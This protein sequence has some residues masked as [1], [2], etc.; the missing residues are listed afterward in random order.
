M[1]SF[2]AVAAAAAVLAAVTTGYLLDPGSPRAQAER[3]ETWITIDA[4]EFLSVSDK[5]RS[6]TGKGFAPSALINGL[7]VIRV[8]EEDL[9]V[10][11]GVMHGHHHKCAGFA[12][13]TS[14]NEA[15][16]AALLTDPAREVEN[17][18]NYTIDNQ[19][20]VTQM[21]PLAA[22]QNIRRTIQDLSS[23]DTRRHDQPSG[24]NSANYINFKWSS[25]TAGRDDI[26]VDFVTHPANVTPQPSVV[27]TITGTTFPDEIV[28]LGGHQDSINSSGATLLAPGA[29][30]NAS[31]IASLT[32]ALRV[33]VE[34][35]FRPARTVQFMAYA[36]EEVGLR[37]SR[38][39]AAN[40]Q[41]QQRN[42]TGVLQL[43]MTNFTSSTTVDIV[44]ITDFTNAAQNQFVTDLVAEYQPQLVVANGTCGYA[45]SDHASWTE[46]GFVSSFP[47]EGALG[48]VRTNN[49]EIHRATDTISVSNN[50]ANHAL[51]FSRLAI[52]F[53]GE[54]AKGSVAAT[55]SAAPFDFDGDGKTDVSIFRPDPSSVA[56]EG[57]SSQ[58]WMLNS[59]DLSTLGLTFGTA[60]DVPVPADYTGDGRTDVTF[61]RPSTGEW[62][63]LRSE[64]YT[65]FAFPFG[66][67]G[68]IPA[69]GDFDGDGR[70][71]AA[72]YRPS[73]GTWF[74]LRSSD[75][76][77]SAVPFGTAEDKPT[78]ADFD[79]DGADDI[80]VYRPSVNQWWQLRSTAGVIGI[81]FGSAGDVSA[82]GDYTGDARADVAFYRPS[83]SEWFVLR[84]EDFSFFAFQWGAPGD[85][86]VPGD[87]DGD[88]ITDAAVFRG[89]DTTWYINRSSSGFQAVPFGAAS[90]TPLPGVFSVQ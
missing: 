41:T 31:G 10:I 67:P 68:D 89:S 38:D 23:Y 66:A 84:S 14:E 59:S 87:F 19:A 48:P 64:D 42:V 18:V 88:G 46:K 73:A 32:E 26:S 24:Q 43:D 70:A 90:D 15:L 4:S 82:I 58:W 1:R 51:K 74:I 30:D 11:S 52:S 36:A 20:N 79:G 27:A 21:I 37:G 77:V 76:N 8:E 49:P 83:T 12:A 86:P 6:E 63:V 56:P 54:L 44:M 69:P 85:I 17:L 22:E 81:Q 53:V 78:V 25:I 72:V 60:A 16:E 61:F 34:T 47:H 80:A 55:P 13:H 75:S 5:L 45:C 28:I 39:I 50:N 62:Y 7:A 35:G 2:R 3:N 33:M 40:Y 65:F 71:D 29:D 57:S 9:A